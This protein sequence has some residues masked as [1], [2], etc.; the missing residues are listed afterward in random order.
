MAN[1]VDRIKPDS[2]GITTYLDNLQRGQYQIPTFQRDVV[3]DRDRVKR[4]WDSIYKFYPLGSVLVW[5]TYT[6]LQNHREI[7]G[8]PLLQEPSGEEFHY[9]LDGQQ[10]TTALLTSMYGGL[11][12][13]QDDRDPTLYVNL[14][15]DTPDDIEDNSWRERFLYW[16]EIDDRGGKLLRN[17]GRKK[18]FDQG[19]IV[20]LKDIAHSYGDVERRLVEAGQTDFDAPC[21]EQLR[22]LKQVLDNYKLSFIE[23]RGIEVGEVC[24]IFERINQAGQPLNMFDIVVAK[25][26][27]PE[28]DDVTGFDL[29]GLCD[30]FRHE[31]DAAGS[32]FAEVDHMTVLQVLAVLVRDAIPDAGVHNITD[33]YLNALRTIHLEQVWEDGTEALRKVYDFLDNQLHLPGPA[34]VPYRYFFM[35]LASYFFRN[36]SPDIALL[37][38]YF[39]YFSFHNDDLLSNTTYLRDHVRRLHTARNGEDFEFGRFVI[40]RQR[41]RSTSYS[42]RGRLSRAVL[43]LYA[44]QCPKDWQ[45]T[46]RSVLTSVYYAL[47]DH[48][49]LHHIF[50]LDFC[51]KHLTDKQDKQYANSLLNIAYLT[52]L[53]NLQISNKNPLKYMNNYIGDDFGSVQRSHLLP[54]T[55]LEW[56]TADSMPEGALITFAERRLDLILDHLRSYLAPL[57]VNVIDSGEL[58]ESEP[59]EQSTAEQLP[60]AYPEGSADMPTGSA[61]G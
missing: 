58:S 30:Q 39:W 37:K 6:R 21:R 53:T 59:V 34:L 48:P 12:K 24:Q 54:D 8:H 20:K 13:G 44:S 10:R 1:Y 33:T 15:V 35:S 18:S 43:A 7:G 22:R 16:D 41:L 23:L 51:E 28:K 56:A 29:R 9:L 47:T 61:E 17:V 32:R 25:T 19:L 45:Q 60:P 42:A 36:P 38:R 14:T 2:Y 3:W 26:F 40:D 57:Q 4:L 31:L 55:V 50:P 49:N 5:R 46:D 52:Q 27:R 11:I